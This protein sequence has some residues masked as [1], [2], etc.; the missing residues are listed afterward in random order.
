MYLV[1]SIALSVLFLALLPYF[2][3][4]S[5]KSGKYLGSFKERFGWL[6]ATGNDLRP[7]IWLHAVSVGEFIAARPLLSALRRENPDH[8]IVVSTTTLSGQRLAR[9][10]V[11]GDF[12]SVFYF[13]FDWAFSV[14][15]VLGRIRPELVIIMETELWPNFLR[16]CRIRGVT[17][18][19]ANGR[20]SQRSFAR[21]MVARKFISRVLDDISLLIMQSEADGERARLLGARTD[22]VRVCGNMKYDLAAGNGQTSVDTGLDRLGLSAFGQLIVAGST[23]QGEEEIVLEAFRLVRATRSL[24]K[25]RLVIAP[26]HPER[27]DEVASLIARSDFTYLRRSEAAKPTEDSIPAVKTNAAHHEAVSV[28]SRPADVVLLDSIGELAAVYRQAAVVFVGGSLVPRGGH[29]IIEPA[30]YAKP[31]V[32]GPHMS[33]F[34]QIV[35]DFAAGDAL[36][37]IESNSATTLAAEL[38][39]LLTD[40][41]IAAALG[42][43]ALDILVKSRGATECTL[44][45]IRGASSTDQPDQRT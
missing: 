45:A 24:E 28:T 25:T 18:V 37:Q 22:R 43:R 35:T 32:V 23:T 11:P 12:D 29:N 34:R 1:Y 38:I 7:T 20:L 21:Y 16:Q 14:R 41:E 30:F 5:A 39:R 6:P 31:I 44:S 26:R 3:Y 27:F 40:T 2:L 13:P 10:F 19:V 36:V 42:A 33:N 9:T 15:R 4:Q 8:R 17:T